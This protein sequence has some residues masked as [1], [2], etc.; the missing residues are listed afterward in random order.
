[1]FNLIDADGDSR[2]TLEEFMMAEDIISKWVIIDD[3]EA[4][5]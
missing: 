3:L 2:I 4:E 1:M 5:F